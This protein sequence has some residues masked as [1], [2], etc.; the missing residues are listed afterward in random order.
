MSRVRRPAISL[1]PPL[2]KSGT[3]S[4]FWGHRTAAVELRDAI[5]LVKS[6]FSETW[7]IGACIARRISHYGYRMLIMGV[8]YTRIPGALIVMALS[9]KA[10]WKRNDSPK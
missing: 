8:R 2:K 4:P 6:G 5:L 3:V 10:G 9:T 1:A 7:R